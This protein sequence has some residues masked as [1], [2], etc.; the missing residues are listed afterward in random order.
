MRKVD[1]QMIRAILNRDSF[2]GGNRR[3]E[4]ENNL[5]RVY[6]H[7]NHIFSMD[8]TGKCMINN[9]G[10]STATTKS[11]LNVLL[12]EFRGATVYQKAYQWFVETKKGDKIEYDGGWMMV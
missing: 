12:Y 1:S 3:V 9:Q 11:I 6:F 5:I 2:N 10:H 8:D 7:G 4:Y